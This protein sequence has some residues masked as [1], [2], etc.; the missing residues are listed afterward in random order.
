MNEYPRS[1]RGIVF[2]FYPPERWLEVTGA[3]VQGRVWAEC[4]VSGGFI[5]LYSRQAPSDLTHFY[6]LLLLGSAFDH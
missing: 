6:F 5:S 4:L 3:A 1:G 2:R